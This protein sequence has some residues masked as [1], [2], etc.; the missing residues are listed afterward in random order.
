MG[1]VED[2]LQVDRDV[3]RALLERLGARDVEQDAF[4]F[5]RVDLEQVD[6]FL[7]DRGA[8]PAVRAEQL[9]AQVGQRLS[10]FLLDEQHEAAGLER[11]AS[12]AH[13]RS[14]HE[15]VRLQ[16]EG[17]V[18]SAEPTSARPCRFPQDFA[19]LLEV[20]LVPEQLS[21]GLHFVELQLSD[22]GA[23]REHFSR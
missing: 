16:L 19:R 18:W 6:F 12:A 23:P 9:R 8:W 17:A 10:D 14:D 1:E 2:L 22:V 20:F 3:L 13:E 11:K 21:E 7:F 4:L 15:Q 5:A